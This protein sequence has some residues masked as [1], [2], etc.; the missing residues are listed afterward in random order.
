MPTY[1]TPLKDMTNLRSEPSTASDDSVLAQLG[2]A[3][4]LSVYGYTHGKD[5]RL[6]WEAEDYRSGVVGY[7]QSQPRRREHHRVVIRRPNP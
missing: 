7:I 6:W 1:V 3:D 5:G 2:M 4:V